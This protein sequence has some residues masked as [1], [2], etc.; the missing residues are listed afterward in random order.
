MKALFRRHS[1]WG[2]SNYQVE[3]Y[4]ISQRVKETASILG[5]DKSL[6]FR[7]PLS[8]SGGEKR[9]CAIAGVMVLNPDILI[10][11]EPTAGMDLKGK[12][13]LLKRLLDYHKKEKRSIILI[14]HVIEEIIDISSKILVLDCG[15]S[16]YYGS[17]E[18]L[19][20]NSIKNLES[21]GIDTPQITKIMSKIKDKGYNISNNIITLSQAQSEIHQLLKKDGV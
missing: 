11:D 21:I 12:K 15:K 7:S 18:G 3:E 5:L 4:E 20:K 17:A 8:L 2:Y 14:S 13:L 19:F 1:L 9:R 16:I 10:L 6:L